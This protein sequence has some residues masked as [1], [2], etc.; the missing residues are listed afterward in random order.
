MDKL[1]GLLVLGGLVLL[2]ACS[3]LPSG[4]ERAVAAQAKARAAGFSWHQTT[5]AGGLPIAWARSPSRAPDS[6]LWVFVEGDG[7]AYIGRSRV[8]LDPTPIN[9]VALDLAL[10]GAVDSLYLGRPCQYVSNPQCQAHWWTGDRYS[11]DLIADYAQFIG[12]TAGDRAL[13]LVGFSGGAVITAG[14]V[15]RVNAVGW[16]TVAGNIDLAF[17]LRWHG[18]SALG[19]SFDPAQNRSALAGVAQLH[20]V[21]A[22][23]RIVPPQ[24]ARNRWPS[25]QI[26]VEPQSHGCCWV[27]PFWR[28]ADGFAER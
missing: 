15:N 1:R 7:L 4:A 3:S 27:E 28:H 11:P 25:T 24:V 21:G 20:L 9:P 2:T 8:S 18:L 16:M 5:L 23:D 17:W 10:G 19:P 26:V 12:A 22:G 6:P 13:V 14:L